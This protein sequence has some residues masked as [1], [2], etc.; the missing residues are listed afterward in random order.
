MG[1]QKHT[2]T[3]TNT[4]EVSVNV[5][6]RLKSRVEKRRLEY[7]SHWLDD[8]ISFPGNPGP[9]LVPL[10]ADVMCIHVLYKLLLMVCELWGHQQL[11]LIFQRPCHQLLGL[12]TT[13]AERHE[14]KS[15]ALIQGFWRKGWGLD[16]IYTI[17]IQIFRC[18]IF[19]GPPISWFRVVANCRGKHSLGRLA[20]CERR[21][22]V[23]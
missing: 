4:I 9:Q 17:Y 11:Y 13:F 23:L 19:P 14:K 8:P 6:S 7:D 2:S 5:I 15:W 21:W 22:Q 10:T 18:A 16:G 3:H 1:L 20:L 12:A